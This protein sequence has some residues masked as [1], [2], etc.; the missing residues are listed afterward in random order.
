MF[1]F[2]G[3]VAFSLLLRKTFK[4]NQILKCQLGAWEFCLSIHW[5]NISYIRYMPKNDGLENS[6]LVCIF[7]SGSWKVNCM[8]FLIGGDFLKV[9]RI[10]VLFKFIWFCFSCISYLPKQLLKC[11]FVFVFRGWF[12][13]DLFW[14]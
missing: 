7:W 9:V 4:Y 2:F 14:K 12:Y 1:L 5:Q 3:T 6:D 11:S 10:L 13:S 8:R